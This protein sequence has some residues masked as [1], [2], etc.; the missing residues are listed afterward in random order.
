MQN[1]RLAARYAKSLIDLAIEQNQLDKITEEVK[2]LQ[3]NAFS[4]KELLG[5]LRS[6]IIKADKKMSILDKVFAGR[7]SKLVHS[8]I[9]L[10]V[11]K[12]RENVLPEIME[13]YIDQYNDL[14]GINHV[15]LTTATP[16]HQES[17]DM[18]MAQ[19]KK[20]TPLEN[21]VIETSVDES[22]IGGYVL[23]LRDYLVD[24]SIK[25]ELA[26]VKRRFVSN[27]YTYNIR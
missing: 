20:K 13:S 27:E 4:N 22:L 24:A 17:I 15:K 19:I 6:P 14:K 8:F 7:I 10:V 21:V 16:M 3:T 26:L 11:K 12:G 9:Q 5:L 1:S 25:R 2:A 18:I 23:E